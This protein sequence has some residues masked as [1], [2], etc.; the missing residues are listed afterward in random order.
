MLTEQRKNNYSEITIIRTIAVIL[1]VFIQHSF[2]PYGQAW[3]F[4]TAPTI[5]LNIYGIICATFNKFSMPL[6]MFISAYYILHYIL[7]RINIKSIKI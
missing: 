5:T 1:V 7:N 2:A 4:A 3:H 6:L